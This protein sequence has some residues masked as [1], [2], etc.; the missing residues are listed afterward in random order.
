MD[1]TSKMP[2]RKFLIKPLY[3]QKRVILPS[4]YVKTNSGLM[5]LLDEASALINL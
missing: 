1:E 2:Q 5:D 3:N 4:I